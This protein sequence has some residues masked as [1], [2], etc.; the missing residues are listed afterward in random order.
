MIQEEKPCFFSKTDLY[1]KKKKKLHEATW[2]FQKHLVI[3]AEFKKAKS[4][5]TNGEP[6][7]ITQRSV[8]VFVVVVL[9]RGLGAFLFAICFHFRNMTW[10]GSHG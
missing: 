9:I 4:D 8:W 2:S 6:N 7:E 10:K 3:S 1:M 5:L